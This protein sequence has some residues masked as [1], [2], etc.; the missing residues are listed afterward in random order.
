MSPIFRSSEK[1]HCQDLA[2]K[3]PV[4]CLPCAC[5]EGSSTIFI[6]PFLFV[7][8]VT[9]AL[10]AKASCTTNPPITLTCEAEEALDMICIGHRTGEVPGCHEHTGLRLNRKS[11]THSATNIDLACLQAVQELGR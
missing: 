4:R 6:L 5:T 8:S 10:Y 11:V 7:L 9:V 1:G 3:A 2:K